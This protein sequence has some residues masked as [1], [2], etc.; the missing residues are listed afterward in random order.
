MLISKILDFLKEICT[1][2]S[3][4]HS[5]D[6]RVL[7]VVTRTLLCSGSNVLG[8][9]AYCCRLLSDLGGF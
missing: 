5:Y 2:L 8:G 6:A 3:K 4:T 1:C 9:F 7:L